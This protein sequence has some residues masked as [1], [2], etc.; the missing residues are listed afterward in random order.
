VQTH[1]KGQGYE[2]GERKLVFVED[3]ELEAARQEA[4]ARPCDSTGAQSR[5]SN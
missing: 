4:R 2:V 3:K 5:T 1:N